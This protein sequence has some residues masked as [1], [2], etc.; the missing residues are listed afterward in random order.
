MVGAMTA[1]VVSLAVT[2]T[3]RMTQTLRIHC[4]RD[5]IRILFLWTGTR[6]EFD[7]H[8]IHSH[9]LWSDHDQE[10]YPGEIV[11]VEEESQYGYED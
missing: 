5:G 8:A 7:Q 3:Q 10:F 4:R 11:F 6:S 1:Q 9:V 2:Q